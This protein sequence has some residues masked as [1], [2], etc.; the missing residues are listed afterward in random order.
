[1]TRLERWLMGRNISWLTWS[2]CDVVLGV[3]RDHRHPWCVSVFKSPVGAHVGDFACAT[4]FAARLVQPIALA[5]YT[6]RLRMYER[7]HP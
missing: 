7:T 6:H 2:G 5:I 4:N 1:M 3:G